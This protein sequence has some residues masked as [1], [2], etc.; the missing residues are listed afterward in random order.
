MNNFELNN[1]TSELLGE[2]VSEHND[3]RKILKRNKS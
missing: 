3:K 1:K 2:Y